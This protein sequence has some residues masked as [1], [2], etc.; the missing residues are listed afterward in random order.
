MIKVYEAQH[1]AEA[2][3]MIGLLEAVGIT[4]QVQGEALMTTM[5]G[6]PAIPGMRPGV[7]IL[8]PN[9]VPRAREVVERFSRGD[10]LTLPGETAWI[11]SGCGEAHE[12]QFG[13]CWQCG[14]A[15]LT[16]PAAPPAVPKD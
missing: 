11:C 8:D 16:T 5:E 7:W 15:R 12:P 13:A 6:A 9:Q 3:M 1:H 2:H 4:A 10:A 14:A